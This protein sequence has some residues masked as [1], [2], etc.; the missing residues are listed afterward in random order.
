MLFDKVVYKNHLVYQISRVIRQP[1]SFQNSYSKYEFFLLAGMITFI[2]NGLQSEHIPECLEIFLYQASQQYQTGLP[3]AIIMP[4]AS[5]VERYLVGQPV[6]ELMVFGQTL[7]TGRAP[8]FYLQW[9]IAVMHFKLQ[10]FQFKQAYKFLIR[11]NAPALA[12]RC[13]Y[14]LY[15]Q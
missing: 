14:S 7:L 10:Q 2:Q 13:V 8:V 3:N 15:F 4:M 1:G 11:S 12:R 6:L 5:V 9:A